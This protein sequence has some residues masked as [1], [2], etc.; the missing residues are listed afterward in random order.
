MESP[1]S[2]VAKK[3]SVP[4][5]IDFLKGYPGQG[6]ATLV[7]LIGDENSGKICF[8]ALLGVPT[9]SISWEMI[10]SIDKRNLGREEALVRINEMIRKGTSELLHLEHNIDDNAFVAHFMAKA[11][12]FGWDKM[13][14]VRALEHAVEDYGGDINLHRD[15]LLK[16]GRARLLYA[17]FDG[18]PPPQARA[19]GDPS[20]TGR[21]A[22]QRVKVIDPA[23]VKAT[24]VEEGGQQQVD[25]MK[26][27]LAQ[28]RAAG[29]IAEMLAPNNELR[30]LRQSLI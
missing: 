28:I 26:N 14:L 15:A 3:V 21:H 23:L 10:R 11:D 9:R 6:N 18:N 20:V 4:Q 12:H 27:W 7:S 19:L 17:K 29:G 24:C 30:Q 13:T 5:I 25:V 2:H 22:T 8:L 16:N 1:S